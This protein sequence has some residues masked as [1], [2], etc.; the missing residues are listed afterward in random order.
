[1]LRF[2]A[3]CIMAISGILTFMVCVVIVKTALSYKYNG[4]EKDRK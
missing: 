4:G 2:L 3:C 1:M